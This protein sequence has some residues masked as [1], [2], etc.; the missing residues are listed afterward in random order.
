MKSDRHSLYTLQAEYLLGK[1][2]EVIQPGVYYVLVADHKTH[3]VLLLVV[4]KPELLRV[5]TSLEYL[6]K[7]RPTQGMLEAIYLV[8]LLVY[9]CN[10]IAADV[11]A[12]RYKCGHGLFV[13]CSQWD[14]ETTRYMDGPSFLQRPDVAQYFGGRISTVFAALVPSESRV[15]VADSQTPNSMPIYFNENCSDLVLPQV[16]RA[17]R[18]IANAVVIAGEYPYIRFYLLP[19]STHAAARLPELIADEVQRQLED[20]LRLHP[21][22]PPA[23]A[24]DKARAVLVVCDRTLDLYAPLLHEFTYQAMAMDIVPDLERNNKYEYTVENERGETQQMLTRLDSEEDAT[25]V[26]LRHMHIIEALEVLVGRISELIRSN[27]L[28]VDRKRANTALEL[29]YVVAHL[30]GFDEERRQVTLHK[31]LIDECLDINATRKLAEFAADFEQTCAAGG[32]SFEGVRNTHLHDD[33]VVLLARSDLHVNDKVRLVLVYSLY[34]GGLAEADFV[35]LARF[36]GVRDTQIISLVLR[37]FFNMRKLDFPIVK[38]SPTEP[39]IKRHAFHTINND[40]TY[41]TSRFAPGLKRVLRAAA[42][43]ELDED[44]FPYF[45]DKPVDDTPKSEGTSLRNPRIKASW[46]PSGRGPASTKNRQRIFCYVAG[47][48]THLEMRSVYEL[49]SALNKDFLLGSES[50]LKPRDFLIGLQSIDEVKHADNLDLALY[51]E[52]TA[53]T[54]A[55]DCLMPKKETVPLTPAMQLHHRHTLSASSQSPRKKLISGGFGTA[56]PNPQLPEVT[57]DPNTPK[58]YQKRTTVAADEKEKK[59]SRFKRFFK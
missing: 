45:S 40:G 54:R 23:L 44:W 28:M 21:E 12:R 26:S 4:T 25:W 50:V 52:L 14:E 22:Y 43:G 7:L 32:T 48:V 49:S 29:M 13:P 27:P 8:E 2:K 51:K 37:C 10:C 56:T 31:T 11:A 9:N 39:A 17:A 18:A 42:T 24:G 35:K 34:R 1:I 53:P 38:K 20:Y 55:P 58:H 6:D 41:N 15:F 47:G 59:L 46:A 57:V 36:I 16:R 5:V 3:A 19:K 30:Q 33:L